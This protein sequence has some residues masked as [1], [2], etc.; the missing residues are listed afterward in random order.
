M[1]KKLAFVFIILIPSLLGFSQSP[2]QDS[3][4]IKKTT[5]SPTQPIDSTFVTYNAY[6][7]D[8]IFLSSSK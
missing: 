8:S 5:V 3:I 7:F 2:T 6:P 4:A 1:P